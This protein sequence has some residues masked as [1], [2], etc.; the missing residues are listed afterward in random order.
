MKKKNPSGEK[1]K[2]VVKDRV[3]KLKELYS[4]FGFESLHEDVDACQQR[5]FKPLSFLPA[6]EF[7]ITALG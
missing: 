3:E 2:K 1:I 5:D 4:S 6:V 7:T